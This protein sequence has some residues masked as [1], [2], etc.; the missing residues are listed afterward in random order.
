MRR[1]VQRLLNRRLVPQLLRV[2][3]RMPVLWDE[4]HADSMPRGDRRR[5][6]FAIAIPIIVQNVVQHMQMVI[7]RAFL[8]NLDPRYLSA[9]GNVMTPY[10][11]VALFLF[12]ASMGL[13]ILVADYKSRVIVQAI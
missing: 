4:H 2:G 1:T 8:G 7:D 11:A 6:I 5:W 3:A 10:N 9:I 12:S 13:T